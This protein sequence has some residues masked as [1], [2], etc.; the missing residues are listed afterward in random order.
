MCVCVHRRAHL[1]IFSQK[2]YGG[3][4]DC[5]FFSIFSY[6]PTPVYHGSL[7]GSSAP[8]HIPWVVRVTLGPPPH[9]GC[10]RCATGL[11]SL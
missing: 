5:S 3:I 4:K 6:L 10:Q 8:K 2:L 9:W 1:R 11:V 7:W